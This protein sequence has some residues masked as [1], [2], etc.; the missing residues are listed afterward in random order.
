VHLNI[1]KP[2]TKNIEELH[3]LF[4]ITITDTFKKDGIG[5][6]VELISSETE[7]KKHFLHKALASDHEES[8]LLTA[9]HQEKIIGVIGYGPSSELI[10]MCTHGAYSNL[11]EI[12][13][14][15]VM[16]EYQGKGVGSQL[17]EAIFAVLRER[18]VH[19][20]CLDS[21]Y[22]SAQKI[23]IKKFGRAD[24][25]VKDHWGEGLDHMIWRRSLD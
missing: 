15:F 20:F 4:I 13:T 9:I 16:P 21:G 19:E 24:Y 2:T 25:I 7:E 6:E 10:K 12:G 22:P 11:G 8:L 23:W 14:A 18:D 17:M 3:Q 5:E 1:C